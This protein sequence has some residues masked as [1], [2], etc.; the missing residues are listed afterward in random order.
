MQKKK[1]AKLY[2]LIG[3]QKVKVEKLLPVIEIIFIFHEK[4][5]F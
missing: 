4:A 2:Q 5:H 1:N 3:Y